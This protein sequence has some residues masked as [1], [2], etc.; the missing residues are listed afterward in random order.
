[1]LNQAL[2]VSRAKTKV[3][4]LVVMESTQLAG[5]SIMRETGAK[6]S[7]TTAALETT[8]TSDPKRSATLFVLV[9]S[10]L[11]KFSVLQFPILS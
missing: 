9:R 2:Y 11:A 6:D 10:N 3:F 5:I 8:I 1:M 7:G 4:A